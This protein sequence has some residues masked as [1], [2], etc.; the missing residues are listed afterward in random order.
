M[1]DIKHVFIVILNE[2]KK[3]RKLLIIIIFKNAPSPSS[4]RTHTKPK[5]KQ[6]NFHF[7]LLLQQPP[8]TSFY[9]DGYIF[10]TQKN[11]EV[12]KVMTRTTKEDSLL[13]FFISFYDL[14]CDTHLFIH[15]CMWDT[16]SWRWR[17]HLIVLMC[18]VPGKKKPYAG[19]EPFWSMRILHSTYNSGEY[20]G[21]K[22]RG[23]SLLSFP[24]QSISTW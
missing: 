11:G 2:S 4:S 23:F 22:E 15:I 17:L 21:L 16:C 1:I 20:Y 6:S 12:I 18:F 5:A 8:H 19:Q 3:D 7:F 24:Y 10:F 13:W 14:Y 9:Q